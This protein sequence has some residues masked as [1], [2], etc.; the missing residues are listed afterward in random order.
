[1]STICGSVGTNLS[2]FGGC[3]SEQI[4]GEKIALPHVLS[5]PLSYQLILVSLQ[6]Y[7]GEIISFIITFSP[8][9]YVLLDIGDLFA[10]DVSLP[11]LIIWFLTLSRHVITWM[12]E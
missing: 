11:E 5:Y 9:Q 12:N 1:M 8:L 4:L 2:H 10:Y 7:H 6:Y 3:Q